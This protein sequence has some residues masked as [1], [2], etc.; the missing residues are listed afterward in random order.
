MNPDTSCHGTKPAVGERFLDPL[1]R[2]WIARDNE[3]VTVYGEAAMLP[4]AENDPDENVGLQP[5]RFEYD[6]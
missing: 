5:S 3:F 4:A 6:A 2:R 1:F